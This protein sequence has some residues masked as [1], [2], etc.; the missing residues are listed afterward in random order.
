MYE[1]RHIINYARIS[2][3]LTPKKS[4]LNFSFYFIFIIFFFHLHFFT[5]GFSFKTLFFHYLNIFNSVNKNTL[6]L[7]VQCK[8]NLAILFK[9]MRQVLKSLSIKVYPS[10]P[11]HLLYLFYCSYIS[12][13][14]SFLVWKIYFR[15]Y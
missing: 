15:A 11:L 6:F 2:L 14:V 3:D 7:R 12:K 13:K 8:I 5:K 9:I 1:H 4:T 10:I